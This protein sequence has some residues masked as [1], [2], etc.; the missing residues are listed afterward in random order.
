MSEREDWAELREILESALDALQ[1]TVPPDEMR[2]TLQQKIADHLYEV[3]DAM[4]L[5]AD[6][7]RAMADEARRQASH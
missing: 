1:R 2:V 3:A 4:Q 7:T 6:A 5:V